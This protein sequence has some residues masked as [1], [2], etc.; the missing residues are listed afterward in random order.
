[1]VDMEKEED[2]S[3][4]ELF[5][6]S[7]QTP[8]AR[9]SPGERVTGTI[10]KISKETVFVDLGGKSE[11]TADLKEFLDEEENPTVHEGEEIELRVSSVR[12]GI[13][14]SRSIKARGA[15]ALDIL[16]DAQRNRIPV[17]GRVAAVNKG[18][19][20]VEIS[21]M[22]GFCPISQIDLHY[23]EKPEEHI[24]QRYPFRITEMK[25][26]GRNIILSRR[27]L[28]QEEQ[29][30]KFQET[31]A[32]LKPGLEVEGKVT[33]LMNFGAFVD[34]GG[35]EGLLHVSEISRARIGHPS[36]VLEPGQIVKVRI[37]KIETDRKGAPRVS[38]SRKV[39]EPEIWDTGLPFREGEVIPGKVS[40]LADFGAFVEVA[41]GVDG[42]VHVSEISYQKVA[43]PNRV[44]KEGDAIEV[45]V[46]K[47]D[48]GKRRLSLSIKEA[49]SRQKA[50]AYAREGGEA[51]LEV[52]QVLPG[53]VED[54]KPYGLFVRLP[55]FGIGVR[56][57]LPMEE[58]MDADKADVKKKFPQ[59]Q[60][61]QVEILAI[62][63]KERIRLS[64]RAKKDREERG[65]Y[66]KYLA[67]GDKAGEMGTL[68]EL[69]KSKL[70]G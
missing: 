9:F 48:E 44:L 13:H 45:L 7:S 68:G 43:H 41:P 36:E 46:L 29:E 70:K 23:C 66:D 15:E 14:L 65:D 31:L 34:I 28:L 8:G 21:G 42:L 61:I 12:R 25:E 33:R 2:I 6:Q 53:I 59:G 50:E 4:A 26:R 32:T 10:V 38:L 69:L 39:F 52:G 55:Q 11:G 58:L 56:G 17:E 22:R 3:F 19:F 20:E 54:H 60:E 35:L 51:R 5:E 30:Q 47:I 40:R 1:M 24:G 37:L 49:Q 57:L 27:V 63:D 18:G 16:R 64:M 62:D 67:R